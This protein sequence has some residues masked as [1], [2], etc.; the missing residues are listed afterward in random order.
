MNFEKGDDRPIDKASI[1]VTVPAGDEEELTTTL[2]LPHC[3]SLRQY[4]EFKKI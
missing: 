2:D 1:S 4:E 3:W